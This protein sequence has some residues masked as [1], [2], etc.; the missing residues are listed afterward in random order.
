MVVKI[1]T[2]KWF[3]VRKGYGV[4][5]PVDGGFDV[6]VSVKAVELAGLS[7]LKEGQKVNFEIV[8]DDRTGELFAEN[9][10]VLLNTQPDIMAGR[11]AL[12]GRRSRWSLR[13]S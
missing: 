7:E 11:A 8:T 10:S 2:V 12:P 9:L 6:Y 5:K 13:M 3:N 4:I 1:G